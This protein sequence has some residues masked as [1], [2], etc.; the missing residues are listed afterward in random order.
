MWLELVLVA[1]VLGVVMTAALG[2]IGLLSQAML[3][4]LW[5]LVPGFIRWPI[6]GWWQKKARRMRMAQARRELRA[7]LGS[8]YIENRLLSCDEI[9]ERE[10]LRRGVCPECGGG[11]SMRA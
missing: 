1:L 6:V 9:M 2:L 7:A 8:G 4:E 10:A 3:E 5:G 11:A